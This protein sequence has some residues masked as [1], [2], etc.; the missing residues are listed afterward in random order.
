M[1]TSSNG[2]GLAKHK[3]F[4]SWVCRLVL[5]IAYSFGREK[6]ESEYYNNNEKLGMGGVYRGEKKK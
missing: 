3:F 4:S 6:K 5:I 1:T 2:G